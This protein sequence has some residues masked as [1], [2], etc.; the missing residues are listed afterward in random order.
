MVTLDAQ[1]LINIANAVWDES[2]TGSTHN[3]PTSSGR[4]LRQLGDTIAGAVNDVSATILSFDTDLIENRDDFFNDQYVRF[5]SGNLEGHV[6]V[7]RDYDGTNKTITTEEAMIEVPD[8]GIEFDIISVHIHPINQIAD[9]IWNT[10]IA[11][12]RSVGSFGEAVGNILGLV[13]QNFYLDNT[14]YNND[15]LLTSARMRI[16]ANSTDA[17]AATDGGID[18][19]ELEI[20]YVTGV[21]ESSDATKIKTYKVTQ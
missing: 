2:L 12:H 15:G 16:F 17:N 19:N 4:R 5:T 20:F 11:D 3:D 10:T 14:I 7:I 13:Q 1:D 8:N 21:A 6:R 9:E 18:E